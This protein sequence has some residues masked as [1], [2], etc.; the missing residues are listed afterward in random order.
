MMKVR[1]WVC[2][3]VQ[4][5]S[6]RT[7][8]NLKVLRDTEVFIKAIHDSQSSQLEAAITSRARDGDISETECWTNLRHHFGR[9]LSY[10]QASEIIISASVRW[11]NLFRGFTITS[12]PSSIPWE[13]PLRGGEDI[14]AEK[15]V[16]HLWD[17]DHDAETLNGAL[18]RAEEMQKLQFDKHLREQAYKKEFQPRVHSE[19]LVHDSLQRRGIDHSSQ[20]WNG[21]KFIGASKP[22][23]RLCQYYFDEHYDKVNVPHSHQNLYRSW[24]LP[25]VTASG[26]RGEMERQSRLALL[27]K[28]T[29]RVRSDV[30][31]TLRDR[32]SPGKRHD[33]NT[34]SY[35]AYGMCP[36]VFSRKSE[37]LSL[38]RVSEASEKGQSHDERVDTPLDEH[39]GYEQEFTFQSETTE[40]GDDDAD[41]EGNGDDDGGVPLLGAGLN[42]LALN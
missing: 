42:L 5:V 14:T 2:L 15:V 25:D 26:P 31:R 24:R 18:T 8:T 30:Q 23:C 11:P 40:V 10:R 7:D 37:S 41:I 4:V 39:R 22:T 17:A 13:N 36:D 1:D 29:K 35:N 16:R 38:S 33:S 9:L 28:I 27:S 20:Y 32:A 6:N 21:W 34:A 3:A 19:V 12:V